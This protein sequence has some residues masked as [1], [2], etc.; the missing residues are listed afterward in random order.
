MNVYGFIDAVIAQDAEKIWPF[1][2]KNAVINWHCTGESFTA[3][4]FIIANCNYP[5]SWRGEIE[6]VE[7]FGFLTV[8]AIRVYPS[9]LSA[10]YH[11]VSFIRCKNGKIVSLDE[12]WSDDGQPPE[13]R[14]KMNI[15][16]PISKGEKR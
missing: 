15:G 2:E 11:C 10:S 9:D 12:Y 5:G 14:K 7:H 4:E 1:F 3:E 16:R 6:R 13:W 8:A